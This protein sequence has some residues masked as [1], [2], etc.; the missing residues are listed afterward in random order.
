M[1]TNPAAYAVVI[2]KAGRNDSACALD[3]PFLSRQHSCVAATKG[4]R[5]PVW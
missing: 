1:N 5:A 2:E 4:L 3:L